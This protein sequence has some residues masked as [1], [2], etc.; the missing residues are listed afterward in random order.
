MKLKRFLL[1]FYNKNT[2]PQNVTRIKSLW[3]TY[4][5]PYMYD[6]YASN[7]MYYLL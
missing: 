1:C 4:M 2:K 7:R 3:I 6:D 5:F